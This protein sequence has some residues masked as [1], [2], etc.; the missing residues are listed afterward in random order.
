MSTRQN[1]AVTFESEWMDDGSLRLRFFD[2]QEN[3]LGQQFVAA[4]A[5]LAL[6]LL[7]SLIDAIARNPDPEAVLEVFRQVDP[8]V[9]IPFIATFMEADRLRAGLSPDG[10]ANLSAL[11]DE[12]S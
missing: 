8:D 9:D 2:Q 7:V 4:E 11:E 5:L 6:Q 1:L 3:I 12:D 10:G